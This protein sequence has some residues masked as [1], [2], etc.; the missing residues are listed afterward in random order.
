MKNLTFNKED[1][2]WYIY[3][4]EWEGD[5]AELEM[6]AGA[7]ILLDHLSHNKDTVSVIVSEEELDDSIIL[8][9]KYN[10][11][12][13]ADYKPVNNDVVYNV[14]LCGVTKFVFGGYMPNKLYLKSLS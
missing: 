6:V 11:N 12:G 8:N 10:I 4:P 9:K 5:K 13:G 2:K 7:D 3:L 1:K 14:W